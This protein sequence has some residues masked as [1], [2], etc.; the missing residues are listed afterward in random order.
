M[1]WQSQNGQGLED[2]KKAFEA[3]YRLDQ[4][5]LFKVEAR[6]AKLIGRW[7]AA[8]LRL[9]GDAAEAY[10][11]AAVEADMAVPGHAGL[12]DKLKADLGQDGEAITAEMQRLLAVAH[13]QILAELMAKKK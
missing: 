6:R 2:R 3:K 10:A 5:V 7:A 1:E 13:E 4:E 8:Q 11:R 9:D 12:V